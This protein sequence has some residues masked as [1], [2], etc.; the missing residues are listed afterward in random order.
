MASVIDS[1]G[2]SA[3]FPYGRSGIRRGDAPGPAQVGLEE[4]LKEGSQHG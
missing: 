2:S 4:P 3:A 1:A